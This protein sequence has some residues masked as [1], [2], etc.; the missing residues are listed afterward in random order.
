MAPTP[1]MVKDKNQT[2]NNYHLGNSNK[3]KIN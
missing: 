1:I 3:Q 2:P